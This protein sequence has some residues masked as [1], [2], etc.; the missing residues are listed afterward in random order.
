MVCSIC[1]LAMNDDQRRTACG[2]MFHSS[3]LDQWL[4]QSPTCPLCRAEL[5]RLNAEDSD[6][7]DAE[8]EGMPDIMDDDFDIFFY[9]PSEMLPLYFFFQAICISRFPNT[10]E[11]T[12]QRIAPGLFQMMM[13]VV[14]QEDFDQLIDDHDGWQRQEVINNF[15]EGAYDDDAPIRA[16]VFDAEM[17]PSM[18]RMVAIYESFVTYTRHNNSNYT[19]YPTMYAL[20]EAF[21]SRLTSQEQYL[22]FR[23][24]QYHAV[25]RTL[26]LRR[27]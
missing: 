14:P 15:F 9:A 11:S 1:L 24:R 20:F 5:P 2:H 21:L 8:D 3:C 6:E 19:V 18:H 17:D 10:N 26:G 27:N 12:M 25:F 16:Y 4:Q 22:L 13:D 23:T 7:T